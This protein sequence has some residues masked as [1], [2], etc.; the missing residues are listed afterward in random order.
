MSYTCI[1]MS[2]QLTSFDCARK[3]QRVTD[4]T[5]FETNGKL[6]VA[7]HL[8]IYKY[9]YSL[10]HG[11]ADDCNEYHELSHLS[12]T[13]S[14]ELS[15]SGDEL[16]SGLMSPSSPASTITSSSMAVHVSTQSTVPTQAACDI[17]KSCHDKPVQPARSTTRFPS[18]LYGKKK[19]SFNPNWFITYQWLD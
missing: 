5:C 9:M 6:H 4:S 1:E 10:A 3:Q 17:S 19:R 18:T 2:K 16:D 7:Q 12:E 11:L 8:T 13:D 14:D 15:L